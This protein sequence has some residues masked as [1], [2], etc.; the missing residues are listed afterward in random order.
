MDKRTEKAIV[1]KL[2]SLK[3]DGDSILYRY[4]L[5]TDL[6]NH[7]HA[8]VLACIMD[9]QISAERAWQIPSK[10][11]NGVENLKGIGSFDL[12]KLL[13]SKKEIRNLFVKGNLHRH[14]NKMAER[15]IRGIERIDKVY[16]GRADRIWQGNK[17]SGDIVC[18]FLEF[19][20]VGIK[21][22]TMA[23]NILV[24]VFKI[25][26][27]DKMAI[28]ISPDVH[29]QRIFKRT[30]LINK[31]NKEIVMY[32]ARSLHPKYPGEIDPELWEIGRKFCRPSNPK[33]EICPLD[34]LCEKHL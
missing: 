24:R 11:K 25:P 6:K 21:V 15:F 10:I 12:N 18:S 27:S 14:K 1:K 20:G 13:K 26:V 29:I 7:P 23:A 19:D 8:F 22:A 28:D 33:C 32:K 4:K 2:L 9:V 30:G 5:I 34:A 16:K 17:P 3:T 31:V